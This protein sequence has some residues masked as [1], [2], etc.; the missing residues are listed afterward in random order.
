MLQRPLMRKALAGP[1][2]VRHAWMH[3]RNKPALEVLEF[4]TALVT[5][6]VRVRVSEFEGEFYLSTSSHLFQ[7][8]ITLGYYESDISA[9]Y[10]KYVQPDR[11]VIDVGANVGFYT[12]LAA[13]HLK[14]GHVLAAE[15]T[16]GAYER[17]EKNVA[18]NGV[19]DRSILFQGL[20]SDT[21]SRQ[22]LFVLPGMEEYSS[23]TPLMHPSIVGREAVSKEIQAR[24]I[25]SLVKEH[26]LNPAL[27][28]VDVEGAEARVFAGAEETLRTARPVVIAEFWP[29]IIESAGSSPDEILKLFERCGYDVFDAHNPRAKS[30]DIVSGEILAIPR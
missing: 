15:P 28:K 24:T 1:L 2:A 7:R 23:M 18:F 22:S 5:N 10:R 20:V 19:A 3:Y 4:L 13:K 30:G 27:L 25:D 16:D 8:I 9:L 14:S 12:V 17:L 26:G 11:D 29:P 21:D 6:D